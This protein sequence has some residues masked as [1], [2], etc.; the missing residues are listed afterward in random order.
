MPWNASEIPNTSSNA[1]AI[2]RRPAPPVS[3]RVPSM[4]KR[5]TRGAS[6]LAVNVAGA[7]PFGRGLLVKVDALA[8]IQLVEA[9]LDGA[10]VEEPLL[11]AFIANKPEP[12]VTNKS[13]DSTV[14]HP[15]LLGRACPRLEISIFVPIQRDIS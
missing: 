2:A 1:R 14:R 3:T 4:S 15:R 12:P 7:R 8:F 9:S 5:M 13:L 6:G 10:T 11:T